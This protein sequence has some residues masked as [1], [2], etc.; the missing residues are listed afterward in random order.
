MTKK[1]KGFWKNFFLIAALYDLILGLVFMLLYKPIF[2][3]LGIIKPVL[4]MYLITSAAFVATMGLGYIYVWK[5][6]FR[7]IDIVKLSIAYKIVYTTIA[8]S[9]YFMGVAHFVFFLFGV[10]DFG[11]LIGFVYFLKW[12]KADGRYLKW[13]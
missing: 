2:D 4:P 6:M 1:D 5:N 7:N 10:L 9:F 3:W 11:F 8:F 13:E 12:A